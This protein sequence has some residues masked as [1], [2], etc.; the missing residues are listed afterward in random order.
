M[1]NHSST[2]GV[3]LCV[4]L[5]LA[6]TALAQ[7]ATTTRSSNTLQPITTPTPV[8]PTVAPPRTLQPAPS[9]APVPSQLGQRPVAPT[10]PT[11]GPAQT[12]VAPAGS[13]VAPTKPMIYDRN[14]RLLQGMQPAGANR[15]LDTKTG[16]YYDAVP[17][18]DGMRVVR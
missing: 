18:G 3:L 7:S 2:R 12:P 6:G 10:I 1:A 15:V 16:R 5:T 14:G 4:L 8:Q 11:R 9:A 17:A 13:Q